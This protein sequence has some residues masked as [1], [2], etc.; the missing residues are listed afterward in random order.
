MV[1]VYAVCELDIKFSWPGGKWLEDI[2]GSGAE[3]SD[4]SFLV[5]VNKK[6]KEMVLPLVK[7]NSITEERISC[8][9]LSWEDFYKK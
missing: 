6:R 3:V 7:C 4:L 2:G 8:L 1:S 9:L 5:S